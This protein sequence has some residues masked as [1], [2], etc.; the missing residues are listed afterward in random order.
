MDF[1]A[2]VSGLS[3]IFFLFNKKFPILH[4]IKKR[5]EYTVITIFVLVSIYSYYYDRRIF[6]KILPYCKN[7]PFLPGFDTI[8]KY[9]SKMILESPKDTNKEDSSVK[10][11]LSESIKKKSGS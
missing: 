1:I 8:F 11:S 10:R 7:N 3:L 6:I 4:I 2:V 9:A 5:L